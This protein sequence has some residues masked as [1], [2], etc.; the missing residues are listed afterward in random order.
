MDGG[1]YIPPHQV[2]PCLP[3]QWQPENDGFP[4]PESPLFKKHVQVPTKTWRGY[5]LA[6]Y[7]VCQDTSEYCKANGSFSGTLTVMLGQSTTTRL[8]GGGH[9][10]ALCAWTSS[11]H[12]HE[13][14]RTLL[15]HPLLSQKPSMFRKAWLG[16]ELEG[17]KCNFRLAQCKNLVKSCPNLSDRY[18]MFIPHLV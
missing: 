15:R 16:C 4:S 14:T 9:P 10:F 5:R 3:K 8:R 12:T 11:Q 1:W 18:K 13:A 17:D 6:M 7:S 2:S